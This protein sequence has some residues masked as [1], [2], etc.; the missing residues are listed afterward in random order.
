MGTGVFSY[1]GFV[2]AIG[3]IEPRFPSLAVEKEAAQATGRAETI[4]LTDSAA[5]QQVLSKRENRYLA[6]QLCWVITV[7]GI[8][9]YLVVPQDP[10]D[11][12]L[13]IES[14]RPAPEPTDL[15]VVIGVQ[16]GTAPPSMCN[17]LTLPV[18]AFEQVYSF[19][20][21]SLVGALADSGAGKGKGG[22]PAAAGELFDRVLH[23]TGNAGASPEHRAVN[24]LAVR[25][26]PLYAQT[27]Q[28]FAEGAG[29]SGVEVRPS[30]LSGAR[31]VVSVII[32]YTNRT[33]GVVSKFAVGVDITD[34]FPF[35]VSNLAPYY[36]I[37]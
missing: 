34:A 6:R 35:V 17:G 37:P 9:T 19:D 25:F 23:M 18:V 10:A 5:F 22:M 26:P 7:R 12:D 33:S 13:L 32:A 21:D 14:V 30:P 27:A 4:G 28:A 29:L 24:Y 11:L 8:E 2:Y 15:D 1:G 31:Q 3:K 20:R 16:T 36:D